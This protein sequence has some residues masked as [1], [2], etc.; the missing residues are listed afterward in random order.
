M[1]SQMERIYRE[2]YIRAYRLR[3]PKCDRVRILTIILSI[4]MIAAAIVLCYS[5]I[6]HAQ[7]AD[8]QSLELVPNN[9]IEIAEDIQETVPMESY[10]IV[11]AMEEHATD[12]IEAT[13]SEEPVQ[14]YFEYVGD[15]LYLSDGN[16]SDVERE[17]PDVVVPLKD[18]EPIT[19]R[20]QLT[21][22]ELE[23]VERVVE[24]EVTGTTYRWNGKN[25]NEEQMLESKIRVVQVFL[26]RAENTERFS[27][28]TTLY[29]AMSETGASSTVLSGRYLRVEVTDLT[30][31]AVQIAL[32][33]NTVDLTDGALFFLADGA[34]YNKYGSYLFTDDV[35][36][37]FFK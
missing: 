10:P 13:P 9:L 23:F 29:E 31:E 21:P 5:Y 14:D 18:E 3:H 17:T 27:H 12:N 8:E 35:G 22:E 20:A 28:V 33:P 24:A 15:T 30:K 2:T 6:V 4:V 11:L 34:T 1:N 7:T 32:D 36:H 16:T 37:S 26:T 19:L 25:V